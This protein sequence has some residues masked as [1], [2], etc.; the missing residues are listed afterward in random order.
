MFN[1]SWHVATEIMDW[2]CPKCV[3]SEIPFNHYIEDN[4]FR[5]AVWTLSLNASSINDIDLYVFEPF[6]FNENRHNPLYDIDPDIQFHLDT[7]YI[8]NTNC[9]YYIEDTFKYIEYLEPR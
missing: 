8:E 7:R 3:Q 1:L 5:Q 4:D 6:F 9:D 2:Y